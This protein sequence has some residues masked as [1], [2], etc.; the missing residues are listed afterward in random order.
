MTSIDSWS[1]YPS[2]QDCVSRLRFWGKNF[3]T[4]VGLEAASGSRVDDDS[5]LHHLHVLRL[6]DRAF[7]PFLF[8]DSSAV[9]V[10]MILEALT[11]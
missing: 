5:H 6:R 1:P 8:A 11:L 3:Q 10:A 4:I 2:R 9:T 7:P